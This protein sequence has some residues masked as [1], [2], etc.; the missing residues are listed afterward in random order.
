MD[1]KLDQAAY[2]RVLRKLKRLINANREFLQPIG[3][4]WAKAVETKL[5]YK[6]Y[7]P[8]RPEQTYIRTGRL[9]KQWRVIV[10]NLKWTFT[11]TRQSKGKFIASWVVGDSDGQNQAWM[12]KSRWWIAK[13]E[14]YKDVPKL[15]ADLSAVLTKDF[16]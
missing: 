7:P 2:N 6:A 1:V 5:R 16:E 14:V 10:G 11:N 13:D 9:A 4:D 3:T 8:K 15:K 12:H